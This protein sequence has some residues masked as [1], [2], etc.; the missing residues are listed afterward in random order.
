[1]LHIGMA[2]TQPKYS[3]EQLGH[4]DD[5]KIRDLDGAVPVQ[6]QD[7]PDWPWNNVPS[8]LTT[9]L[10]VQDVHRRW[11][12]HLPVSRLRER[13]IEKT[14][15]AET[16][17]QHNQIPLMVSSNAGHF[18]CDYIFF[19]SLA[20]CFKA[21]ETRRVA[22]LHVPAAKAAPEDLYE[23]HIKVGREIA[24]QLIRSVVESELSKPN[25]AT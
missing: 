12:K 10:D 9:D 17:W 14:Q 19:N 5:Y 4:R 23:G 24:T 7:S 8:Q 21:N 15:R 16:S 22:F 25:L 13:Q 2:S 20:Q 11:N 1:M 18:L 6:D 3:L